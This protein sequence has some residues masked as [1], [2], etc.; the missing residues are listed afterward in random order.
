MA[1]GAA[2]VGA[3]A[4]KAVI[5]GRV[6]G[7]DG[8]PLPMAH[9]NITR[10][11]V[12]KPLG[13]LEVAK[14][15]S[16]SIATDETGFVVLEV[17]GVGHRM[18]PVALI[19]GDSIRT[20]LTVQLQPLKYFKSFDTIKVIGDFNDF[21]YESPKVMERYDDGCYELEIPVSTP[22]VA[23]QLIGITDEGAVNAPG[24]EEFSYGGGI[25]YRSIARAKNGKVKISFDSTQLVYTKKKAEVHFSDPRLDAVASVYNDIL[26]RRDLY[27]N[28]LVEN[29]KAGRSLN[30]FSYN[31]SGT[32]DRLAK[33]LALE[34]DSVVREM[35][36]MGYLDLGT[37]DGAKQV[38]AGIAKWALAAIPPTSPV[39]SIN[40]KLMTLAIE[41][42]GDPDSLYQ[43]YLDEAV[44][45]H[46][47][48]NVSAM[49][50]YDQLTV[51]YNT[52]QA[53]RARQYYDRLTSTY[54]SSRYAAMARVQ[55]TIA[56][57]D[58]QG[59]IN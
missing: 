37:L 11:N 4:Q 51:A 12:M 30:E 44:N 14:D 18:Q 19:L 16:F 5:N 32:F 26:T 25:F 1:L 59:S 33:G 17:S 20:D 54:S 53:D 9:V 34:K 45:H 8:Q 40:P 2:T 46:A 13:T 28:A 36:L 7:Y 21:S 39:W 3:S 31:W 56:R 58:E 23:Y 47:D 42:S 52:N 41:K 50:L 22:T 48:P 27:Q 57:N 43:D 35:M 38:R 55:F 10:L 29:R 24:S 6:V 15:G 49:L